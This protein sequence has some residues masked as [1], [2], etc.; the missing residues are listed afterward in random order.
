[1]CETVKALGRVPVWVRGLQLGC[2]LLLA[3]LQCLAQHYTFAQFGQVDGLLNQDVSALVQDRQGVLWA[4]TE[5][6]L[7]QADGSRFTR[8]ESYRDAEYGAVTAMHADSQGRVWVLGAKKLVYFGQ[9]QVLHVVPAIEQSLLLEGGIALASLPEQPD[10]LF[11]LRAGQLDRVH[12]TDGGRSWSVAPLQLSGPSARSPEG[13]NSLIPDAGHGRLWAGCGTGVCELHP[14]RFGGAAVSVWDASRG[15]PANRWTALLLARDGTLWARGTGEV[16]RLDAQ[17]HFVVR[18]GDPSNMEVPE[19][20]DSTLAEDPNGSI[21]ANVPDGLA[22]LKDGKWSRLGSASGLPPS[23]I[24]AMFFARD[25]GLWL[26]PMGGGIWRWLGYSNWQ[27]WTRSEGL[28]SN[29]ISSVLRDKQ[30]RLWIAETNNLD[31]LDEARGRALQ[32]GSGQELRGTQSVSLD[33]RGHLWAG[34]SRGTLVDF[35]PATR[36]AHTVADTLGFVYRVWSD[37]EGKRVWVCSARGVGSVSAE[38]GWRFLR[39]VHDAGAPVQNAWSVTR[40]PAGALW[41]TA[42]GG[43]YRFAGD[44]WTH[45]Q[46]PDGS[47]LMDYPVLSAAPDGTFWLQAPLPTP[48]LHLRMVGDHAQVL[49]TIPESTIGSDD[50]SSVTFDRRHWMWVG[51]DLGLFVFDGQRWVHCTQ[52]DGLISDDTDTSS[53]LEDADGSMW[54]GTAAGLSHL[55]H[56]ERLFRVA[57]PEVS[58]REVRLGGRELQAG[59]PLRLQLKEPEL[60]AELFSTYYGRPRA[61]QFQYRLEPVQSQWITAGSNHL[62]FSGLVP[63]DYTLS[64]QALDKRVGTVSNPVHYTFTLLPPWYQRDRSKVVALLLALLLGFSAWRLSLRQLKASEATLK[65]KVDR[66][67]AQLLAEKAEL[68]RTQREL[69]ETARRDALTG[70]LNRSAIFEVLRLMRDAAL[71]SGTMLSVIMADL[72]HFKSV[73]DRYGHAAGDAVLQEC[74]ERF[75]ATLRPGDSVGRYGGEEL[76]II[77]P[78]LQPSHALARVE[79]IREAVASRRVEHA[80][81]QIQVTCSFGV[82]WLDHNQ[83][84]AELAVQLADAALYRAKQEGRNRIAFA[85]QMSPQVV[86]MK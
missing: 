20:D 5:N 29:V 71:E 24:T 30:A 75:R 40:D 49:G 21:L 28:S 67:T 70:L 60:T 80:G 14:D 7:F 19:L 12:S 34:T 2:L 31:L 43:I 59:R 68:E 61:V 53:I 48:L 63:G 11:L 78:G 41:F 6:G 26:A 23:Q 8:L 58:V 69:V 56:P 76:L 77:I 85:P 15:V 55:L 10:T 81:Q 54:F 82:A 9:D 84:Q 44:R 50:I 32:M 42:S 13:F 16:L 1:M 73:N 83:P 39:P 45:I 51:T 74:A 33:G 86:E 47:K 36:Q 35:D 72:D 18:Y 57:V 17:L 4:G 27:G 25:G 65:N 38:D 3:C 46:F 64:V 62:R 22:R 79:A 37:G 52:E 66:Q